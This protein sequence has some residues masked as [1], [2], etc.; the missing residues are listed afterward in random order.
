VFFPDE[1][2]IKMASVNAIT[3]NNGRFAFMVLEFRRINLVKEFAKV[4]RPCYNLRRHNYQAAPPHPQ[5]VRRRY[6]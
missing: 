2:L 3:K 6:Y 4:K 1:Q 5:Q